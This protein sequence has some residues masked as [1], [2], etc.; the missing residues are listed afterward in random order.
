M[1]DPGPDFEASIDGDTDTVVLEEGEPFADADGDE[2]AESE[3]LDVRENSDVTVPS[4][5]RET[6]AEPVDDGDRTAETV[7]RTDADDDFVPS[8]VVLSVACAEN[9]VETVGE[10]VICAEIESTADDVDDIVDEKLLRLVPETVGDIVEKAD[11][12]DC[13]VVVE[14]TEEDG[15]D[16]EID[17]LV[18][19]TRADMVNVDV[20]V[21]VAHTVANALTVKEADT[22]DVTGLVAETLP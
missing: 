10:T 8:A 18:R 19:E 2:M 9:V 21:A 1:R 14:L 7:S 13:A 22:V 16:E 17:E 6:E 12:D 15:D 3:K 5:V 4:K 20:V 11:G